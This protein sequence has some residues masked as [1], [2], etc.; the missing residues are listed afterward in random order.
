MSVQSKAEYYSIYFCDFRL[1]PIKLQ[2]KKERK[3]K[4]DLVLN[5]IT[6]KDKQNMSELISLFLS[7]D[8]HV[9]I[10]LM[11]MILNAAG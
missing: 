10:E 5:Y 6:S 8:F 9:F 4:C 7:S 1:K 11:K 2:E 3:L